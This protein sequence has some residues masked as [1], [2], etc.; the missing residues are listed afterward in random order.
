MDDTGIPLCLVTAVYSYLR[1]I[2]L[3]ELF[4]S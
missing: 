3:H 4:R 2:D 1:V